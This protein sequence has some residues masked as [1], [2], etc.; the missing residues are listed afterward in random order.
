MGAKNRHSIEARNADLSNVLLEVI[1]VMLKKRAEVF[2]RS[3]K[4][5]G[6]FFERLQ[7]YSTQSVSLG[8]PNKGSNCE[9]KILAYKKNYAFSVFC[10]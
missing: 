4:T 1:T 3:I 6:E 2:Y 9:G 10:I 8:S 5:R 7:K